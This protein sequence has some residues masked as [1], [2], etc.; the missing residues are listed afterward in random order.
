MVERLAEAMTDLED[1]LS[2]LNSLYIPTRF[3]DGLPKGA[4][5]DHFGCVQSSDAIG[6]ARALIK[7]IHLALMLL[8]VAPGLCANFWDACSIGR[9]D[10]DWL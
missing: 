9:G 4:P 6:H 2:V 10:K 5:T 1:P 8:T 3:A 7:A